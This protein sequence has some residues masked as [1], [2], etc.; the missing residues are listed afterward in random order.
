MKLF[1]LYN[2]LQILT[3]ERIRKNLEELGR[4]LLH[5][6]HAFTLKKYYLVLAV[7]YYF[8]GL[9]VFA[10]QDSAVYKSTV[11]AVGLISDNT[12]VIASG[13]FVNGNTFITNYHVS[14]ELNIDSSFI[15]MK[16]GREFNVR[17]VIFQ[18]YET[19]LAILETYE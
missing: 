17:K 18:S 14:N 10:Q 8:A 15:D 1:F 19:D 9:N 3:W 7:V 11:D 12:G 13:F 6:R 5:V 4:T 2:T 16:D